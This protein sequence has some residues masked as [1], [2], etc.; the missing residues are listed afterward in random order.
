M[1][2]RGI[3]LELSVKITDFCNA[4]GLYDEILDTSTYQNNVGTLLSTYIELI[5]VLFYK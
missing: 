5:K 2:T 4:I 3:A 1:E